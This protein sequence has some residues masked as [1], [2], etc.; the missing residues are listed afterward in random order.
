MY[1][2]AS[3]VLSSIIEKD[4]FWIYHSVFDLWAQNINKYANGH[5]CVCGKLR[6]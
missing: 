2:V 1:N 3:G 4:A 5:M 6:S